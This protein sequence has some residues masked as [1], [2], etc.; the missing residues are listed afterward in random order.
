MAQRKLGNQ[1][2]PR[3]ADNRGGTYLA[4]NV[5]TATVHPGRSARLVRRAEEHRRNGYETV[6]SYPG[7]HPI[8]HEKRLWGF[9][10]IQKED[11][12][13]FNLDNR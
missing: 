3:T 11:G 12:E 7:V 8:V 1:G 13:D 4:V 2:R 10:R 6:I 5:E 9:W